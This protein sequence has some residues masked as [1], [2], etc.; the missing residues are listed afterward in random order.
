MP[1]SVLSFFLPEKDL[2]RRAV[3]YVIL[4][5]PIFQPIFWKKKLNENCHPHKQHKNNVNFLLTEK[6]IFLQKN[7]IE[8]V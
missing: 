2:D 8:I 4:H 6:Y 1:K 5:N 7:G 3:V